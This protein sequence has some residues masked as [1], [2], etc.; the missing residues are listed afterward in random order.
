MGRRSRA[1]PRVNARPPSAAGGRGAPTGSA[2]PRLLRLLNPRKSPT[3]SR[4]GAAAAMFAGLSLT[5]VMLGLVVSRAYLQPA[6]LTALLA[7]LWGARAAT[8]R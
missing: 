1:R 6:L 4:V 5:L 8:M 2:R 3:R 7:L